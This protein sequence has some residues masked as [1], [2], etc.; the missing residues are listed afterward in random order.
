VTKLGNPPP[1]GELAKVPAAIQTLAAG[2]RLWRVYFRG[3]GHPTTWSAFRAHG[4][5]SS[6]FD[7]QLSVAPGQQKIADG[8]APEICYAALDG[9]TCLA[10]VFQ[11]SRII[12]C[13]RD[14]PWLVSFRIEQ[15][16]ELLDLTGLWPTRAGTS[17]VINN[18]PKHRTRAWSRTIYD[19]YPVV[20]G[21]YYR[22]PM[23][24]TPCV[25]LYERAR[26]TG[27]L[28]NSPS[29]HRSL[30]DP[31]IRALLLSTA[32]KIGYRID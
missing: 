2:T 7:H 13:T 19:A 10:E 30:G 25:A 15:P 31:S 9:A 29:F 28:P 1:P 20:H 6:R 26:G 27:F 4:P 23:T 16:L 12:D 17:S 18:G 14:H 24:S 21:L 3:G 8:T 22:S 11:T 32:A 5:T